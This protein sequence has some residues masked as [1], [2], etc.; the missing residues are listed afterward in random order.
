MDNLTSH[1]NN[2]DNNTRPQVGESQQL[3]I[4]PKSN[5]PYIQEENLLSS[6]IAKQQ[7]E[8]SPVIKTRVI[9][10]AS[11]NLNILGNQEDSYNSI[12]SMRQVL[13]NSTEDS[14]VNVSKINPIRVA[15]EINT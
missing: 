3:N 2:S 5:P 15:N 11:L 8:P 14:P 4:R 13:I 9:Q 1:P 12:T 6:Q 10:A 7:I